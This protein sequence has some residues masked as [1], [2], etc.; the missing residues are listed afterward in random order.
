MSLKVPPFG[1]SL[2]SLVSCEHIFKSALDDQ[3]LHGY[4]VSA[5]PSAGQ[6]IPGRTGLGASLLFLLFLLF[7]VNS[8]SNEA[9]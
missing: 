7:Q 2:V 1:A 5:K 6:Q 9:G 3:T 4:C 8:I